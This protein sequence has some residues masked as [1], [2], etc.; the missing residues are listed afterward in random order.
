MDKRIEDLFTAPDVILD[1]SVLYNEAVHHNLLDLGYEYD[2]RD[3]KGQDDEYSH[4][5]C[6]D[7]F[8]INAYGRINPLDA[9]EFTQGS[10]RGRKILDEQGPWAFMNIHLAD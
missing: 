8:A 1:N 6:D 10:V 9:C 4:P 7:W 5:D 3:E 2:G